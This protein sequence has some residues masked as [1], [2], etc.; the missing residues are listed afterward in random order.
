MQALWG[1]T[2][3]YSQPQVAIS[4]TAVFG[5]SYCIP[6]AKC[7]GKIEFKFIRFF[8]FNKEITS[9]IKDNVKEIFF[10]AGHFKNAFLIKKKSSFVIGYHKVRFL[11]VGGSVYGVCAV[12]VCV[13][14]S[15]FFSLCPYYLSPETHLA[16]LPTFN[17]CSTNCCCLHTSWQY[18][19]THTH[20]HFLG[21]RITPQPTKKRDAHAVMV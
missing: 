4:W 3:F 10:I 16:S 8:Y 1:V 7:L 17:S 13:F 6:R 15:S 9:E 18:T 11:C 14:I 19:H 21:L 2:R 5:S 12:C 20:I